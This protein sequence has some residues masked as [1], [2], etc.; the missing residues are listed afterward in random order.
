MTE[1]QLDECLFKKAE[2]RSR[3]LQRPEP[4]WPTLGK[5][6]KRKGVTLRL[7]WQEYRENY[8]E[9]YGYSQFCQHYRNWSKT[10]PVS[11]R[12]NHKTGEKLFVDYAGMTMP[13][14]TRYRYRYQVNIGIGTR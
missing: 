12:Q 1:E 11:M 5:E 13:I 14:G 6:F 4:D 10:I 2:V 3:D 8:N 9:G 7:L